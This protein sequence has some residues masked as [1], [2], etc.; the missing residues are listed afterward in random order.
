MA[1]RRPPRCEHE[2]RSDAWLFYSTKNDFWRVADPAAHMAYDLCWRNEGD[3]QGQYG[4]HSRGGAGGTADGHGYGYDIGAGDADGYSEVAYEV[5]REIELRRHFM[6][7]ANDDARRTD[8]VFLC[9][10]CVGG[11]ECSIHGVRL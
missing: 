10:G 6:L 2:P 5:D 1:T 7:A 4:G 8:R 9:A 11:Y 3:G